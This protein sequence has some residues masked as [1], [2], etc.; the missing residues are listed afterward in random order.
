MTLLRVFA[1]IVWLCSGSAF[2]QQKPDPDGAQKKQFTLFPERPNFPFAEANPVN[3][4]RLNEPLQFADAPR[5]LPADT[6][7]Y[8]ISSYVV[9]RDKKNSDS[10]HIVGYST[11]QPAN[12]YRLK[13]VESH[14]S[15]EDVKLSLP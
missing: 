3:P 9:A 13:S 7:C 6:T 2:A 1:V 14:G 11:C 15:E 12:R 10:T 5:S 4:L 8:V